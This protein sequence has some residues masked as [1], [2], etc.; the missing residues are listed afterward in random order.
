M[1]TPPSKS[2]SIPLKRERTVC[3]VVLRPY[4]SSACVFCRPLWQDSRMP[5]KEWQKQLA[6]ASR[7]LKEFRREGFEKID[8]SGGDP[9]EF[10][11]LP[12]FIRE[13]RRL[14]FRWIRVST[15][16]VRLADKAF[17]RRLVASGVDAFRIPLYGAD[18]NVH[19]KVTRA[20]GSFQA[21]VRGIKNIKRSGAPQ[22]LLTSLLL[23]QTKNVLEDTFDLMYA[24][25]CDDLYFAPAFVSNDDYSYYVPQKFQGRYWRR[26]LRHALRLRRP[27]RFCDVPFCVLGFDNDFTDNTQKPAFLGSYFQPSGGQ[28]T[29]VPDLPR[30]RRKIKVKICAH[31]A[32]A[33][34]CDGFLVNDILR[35]GIGNLKPVRPD[36]RA[37]A[38]ALVIPAHKRS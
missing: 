4:C 17:A 23:Q 26:L 22:V 15:N 7:A 37:L 29:A 10:L 24:L 21:T 19:D 5:R 11:G 27:V 9:L 32:A 6:D 1:A 20:T 30:Y 14:G 2:S 16:G 28:K 12:A 25:G 35:Y 31:C 38:S 13:A 18:H 8:V 34:R 36:K 33:G 3:S